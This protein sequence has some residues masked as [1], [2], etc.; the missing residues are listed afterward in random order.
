MRTRSDPAIEH[1][2]L[3]P[4]FGEPVVSQ[5][6]LPPHHPGQAN[7]VWEVFTPTGR[8]AVRSPRSITVPDEDFGQGV[9]RLFDAQSAHVERIGVI[10]RCLQPVSAYPLPRVIRPERFDGRDFTIMEWMPGDPLRR[11]DDLSPTEL[12][13]LGHHIASLHN[14]RFPVFGSPLAMKDVKHGRP[15]DQFVSAAHSVARWVV[16]RY[17]NDD[18]R[19]WRWLEMIRPLWDLLPSP[20]YAVPVMIDMDP[21]QFLA[22]RGTITALVDTE[23]YVLAPPELEL[24][25]LEMLLTPAAADSFREGYR[26]VAPMPAF[27]AYRAPF[28]MLL[29]L[30][31]FQGPV[32]WDEWMN[33]RCAWE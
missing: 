20:S 25:G 27:S 17:Y 29:R 21:T 4:L 5:R 8:V 23:L 6:L 33:W 7:Y 32:D 16:Q 14:Q 30:L 11:F 22:D 18:E 3:T 1:L 2:S 12:G 26:A 13:R 31:S 10:N 9:L 15:L 28:R 24:A 19:A